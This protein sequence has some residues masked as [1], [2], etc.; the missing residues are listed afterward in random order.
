MGCS[1]THPPVGSMSIDSDLLTTICPCARSTPMGISRGI[2]DVLTLTDLQLVQFLLPG[3]IDLDRAQQL[4]FAGNGPRGIVFRHVFR[5][6]RQFVLPRVDGLVLRMSEASDEGTS[7]S[8]R[9]DATVL[10]VVEELCLILD[11]PCR[12]L[13]LQ[14]L[15]DRDQRSTTFGGN[16]TIPSR[17][18]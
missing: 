4:V 16:R 12:N 5:C 9:L 10:H 11:D 14:Q 18:C 17:P 13:A 1:P 15:I 7:M 8:Q 6:G 3:K 2:L